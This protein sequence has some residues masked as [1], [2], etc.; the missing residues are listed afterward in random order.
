MQAGH[1]VLRQGAHRVDVDVIGSDQFNDLIEQMVETMREAPGV[2]LAAPQIGLPLQ[3]CVIEHRNEFVD[4]VPDDVRELHE[5][6]PVPLTVLVNPV[7]KPVG[8]Q[9]T[10]FHEGC[11]SVA[12]WMAE[13]PRYRRVKVG[14]LDH[15]GEEV[16]LDWSGWPARIAQHEVD[17]LHGVLYVDRMDPKTF[18]TIQSRLAAEFGELDD[19]HFDYT[20]DVMRAE[21]FDQDRDGNTD[22]NDDDNPDDDDR[23]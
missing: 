4:A 23:A 3:L 8:K 12:G 1:P 13:T 9:A 19:D 20:F 7:I 10:S 22:D 15:N 11:L 6:K 2:G 14:A 21:L 16:L 17:H 5:K 18:C